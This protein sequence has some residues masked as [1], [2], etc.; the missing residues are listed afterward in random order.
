MSLPLVF[1]AYAIIAFVAG[2]VLYSSPG[3][4][5]SAGTYASV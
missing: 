4:A 2:V 1:L 5:G 3:S